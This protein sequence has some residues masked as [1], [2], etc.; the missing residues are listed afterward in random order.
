MVQGNLNLVTTSM[1]PVTFPGEPRAPDNR[2]QDF[3]NLL[4][5]GD[6]EIPVIILAGEDV[7]PLRKNFHLHREL[8][9]LWEGAHLLPS[10]CLEVPFQGNPLGH[11]NG[12]QAVLPDSTFKHPCYLVIPSSGVKPSSP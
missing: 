2:S 3:T 4:A 8:S 7:G 6:L 1:A 10:Q 5:S 11:S 9:H 12:L